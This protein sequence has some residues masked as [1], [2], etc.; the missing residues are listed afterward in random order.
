VTDEEHDRSVPDPGRG[1]PGRLLAE[2]RGARVFLIDDGWLLRRFRNRRQDATTEAAVLRWAAEHGVPV[3]AVREAVG[4]DLVLEHVHGRS[5]LT[6]LL[7]EPAAASA[8][9][10]ALAELHGRLDPVPAPPWLQ[11]PTGRAGRLLHGD[12][13]PGNVLL[14]ATGPVLIDWTNAASG[15]SAYDTATTWLVLACLEPPDPEVGMQLAALRPS[16]L[17]GFLSGIDRSAAVAAMP[18]VAAGRIAD[19]GTTDAERARIEAFADEINR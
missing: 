1:E 12:L 3:P 8:H 17:D 6:A 11:A 16:V 18:Q 7:D 13:H 14:S 19:P 5:M 15:P 10:R 2:G 4:P 9:G